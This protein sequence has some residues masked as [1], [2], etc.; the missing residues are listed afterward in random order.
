MKKKIK[1]YYFITDAGLS[2]AGIFKDTKDAL[3]TGTKIV[4]YRAKDVSARIMLAEAVRFKKLCGRAVFIVNDRVDVAV[5]SGADG[6]HIGQ[7]DISCRTARKILGKNKIIGITVW[8]VSQTKKAIKDGADYIAVAP[9]FETATKKDAGY[10]V[11]FK[12]I[13]KIK[14]ISILKIMMR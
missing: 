12:L 5:A 4:Q 7:S 6:V 8:N 2:R 11:G 9:V 10:P 1:G 14:K 13:Q 3:R